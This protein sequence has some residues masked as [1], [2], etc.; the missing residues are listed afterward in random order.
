MCVVRTLVVMLCQQVC[1]IIVNGRPRAGQPLGDVYWQ[2]FG[3]LKA[4]CHVKDA[5]RS[6]ATCGGAVSSRQ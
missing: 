2:G 1:S 3:V 4:V 6:C 5:V